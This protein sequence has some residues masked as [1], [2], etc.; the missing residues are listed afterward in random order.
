MKNYEVFEWEFRMPSSSENG[1]G[2]M[3]AITDISNR[4][5]K[6]NSNTDDIYRSKVEPTIPQ[7][8]MELS[9]LFN[10]KT[11]GWLVPH[12]QTRLIHSGSSLQL[13]LKKRLT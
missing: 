3:K 8:L 11:A 4:I 12:V 2:H 9:S 1:D 6:S 7:L 5:R 13:Q 10:I